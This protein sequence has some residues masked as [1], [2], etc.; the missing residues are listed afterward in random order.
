MNKPILPKD[1]SWILKKLMDHGF[2]GYIVGGCVRDALMDI[3]PHDWDMTTSATPQEVKN[4]FNHTVDTGIQHG[5]V[6]VV[7]N[8]ENYEITTYRVD[9]DYQDCRRP[10]HVSFTRDLHQDLLRRDFTMNAIAYSENEGYVD[11]FGGIE[12]INDRI[13]RGVG[14]AAERFREDALRML[15]AIRFSV[16]LDFEIEA[17]TKKALK[18]NAGLIKKI[19]A[20]RIREELTKTI[21]GNALNRLPVLWETGLLKYISEELFASVEKKGP[22]VISQ[23]QNVEKN[24]A[25]AYAVFLQYMNVSKAKKILQE[26]RFDTKTLRLTHTILSNMDVHIDASPFRV[27][28]FAAE[29]GT[30]ALENLYKVRFAGGEEEAAKAMETLKGV[31]ERGDC[32]RVKDL[33]LSGNGLMELGIEKGKNMGKILDEL[34]DVVLENPDLNKKDVLEKWVRVNYL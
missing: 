9:G 34:L 11:I 20:E 15:R 13:I 26:L 29:I 23:L 14:V 2:E 28:K 8:G 5:T 4:I 18:E 6:T 3:S 1:V 22:H 12:D 10:T 32:I 17:E 27:R 33:A 16:Q 19:S 7:L 25:M 24:T 31:V 30:D 21:T